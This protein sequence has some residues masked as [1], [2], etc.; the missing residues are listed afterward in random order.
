M[1]FI[2]VVLSGVN[3]TVLSVLTITKMLTIKSEV[4]CEMTH[5]LGGRDMTQLVVKSITG[6]HDLFNTILSNGIDS[7]LR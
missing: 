7:T 6:S 5:S 1:C 4:S 3:Y 2:L